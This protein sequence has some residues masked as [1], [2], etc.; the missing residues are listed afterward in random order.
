[1]H[2]SVEHLRQRWTPEL[3]AAAIQLLQGHP[4][5]VKVPTMEHEGRNY[6]DLRG[7]RIEQTQ[8]DEVSLFGQRG[9]QRVVVVLETAGPLSLVV[10]QDDG[11]GLCGEV[12]DPGRGICLRIRAVDDDLVG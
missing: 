12:A 1:M 2:D 10:A 5:A 11:V 7:I 9:F 6:L 3:T 4:S 8:L